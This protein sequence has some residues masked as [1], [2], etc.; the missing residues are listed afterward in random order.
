[1]N[2]WSWGSALKLDTKAMLKAVADGVFKKARQ[3]YEKASP[4]VHILSAGCDA[5]CQ[6]KCK[7]NE[8]GDGIAIKDIEKAI[9]RYS[10]RAARAAAFSA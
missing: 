4:F 5:P 9:A 7:L 3:I 8:L 2:I 10:A 1:M 6:A